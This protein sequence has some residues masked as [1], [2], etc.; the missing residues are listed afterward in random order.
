[1]SE[2]RHTVLDA[3]HFLKQHVYDP[4]AIYG[5]ELVKESFPDM[6]EP[7]QDPLDLLTEFLA[8]LEAL[9]PWGAFTAA[10]YMLIEVEKLKKKTPHERHY[11]LLCMVFS[12]FLKIR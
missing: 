2:L 10:V 12:V 1:M 8:I 11:L 7:Q 4:C 3:M 6:A 5:E 9:G